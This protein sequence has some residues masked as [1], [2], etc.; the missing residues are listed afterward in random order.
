MLKKISEHT[1]YYI[2]LITILSLGFALAYSSSNRSFQI[3]VTVATTFFY[4]LWGLL[5]HLINHD[6]H[7]KIVIEYILIG[8]FGLTAIF[9]LLSISGNY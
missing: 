5:H 9:F 1:I 3:G 6:L 7:A 8:A 2:I 4:V